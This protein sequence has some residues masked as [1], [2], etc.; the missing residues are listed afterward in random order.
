MNGTTSDVWEVM[1]TARTIRRFTDLRS[2]TEPWLG[3]SKQRGGA[4]GANAQRWRFVVLRPPEARDAVAR[5]SPGTRV[6]ETV[7]GMSGRHGDDSPAARTNRATNELHDR[8]GEYTSVLFAQ[9]HFPTASSCCSVDRLPRHAELPARGAGTRAGRVHDQLGVVRRRGNPA[10]GGGRA[11]DWMFAGHIVVGWP[12][13]R[14]GRVRRRPLADAVNLDRWDSPPTPSSRPNSKRRRA[15]LTAAGPRGGCSGAATNPTSREPSARR[16]PRSRVPRQRGS[17]HPPMSSITEVTPTTGTR[18][19]HT[20]TRRRRRVTARRPLPRPAG[21]ARRH[22]STTPSAAGLRRRRRTPTPGRGAATTCARAGRHDHRQRPRWS[23]CNRSPV[24]GGWRSRRTDH[25]GSVSV[26]AGDVTA[27]RAG[28]VERPIAVRPSIVRPSLVD[29]K[30]ASR[31]GT[32]R[33]R[34][35]ARRRAPRS[36]STRP[37]EASVA[38]PPLL[39]VADPHR[40]HGEDDREDGQLGAISVSKPQNAPSPITTAEAVR[41]TR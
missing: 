18:S 26:G 7:Y 16:A 38:D 8:A 32:G 34:P 15:Q 14:H 20:G 1:S 33:S 27:A 12:G 21:R 6:I 37:R 4:S 29:T 17:D 22:R 11:D 39:R 40:R 25:L 30:F 3:A 24:T 19:G 9:M 28:P 5:S 13:G 41:T 23:A 31:N 10:R 36:R 35:T 2:T